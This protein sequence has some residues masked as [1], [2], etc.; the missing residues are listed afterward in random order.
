MTVFPK[1]DAQSVR[2]GI[3]LNVRFWPKADAR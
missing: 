2:L 1:A 3:E